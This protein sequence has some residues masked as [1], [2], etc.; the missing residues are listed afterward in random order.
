MA[1]NDYDVVVVGGGP[2]GSSAA[3][4]L[5]GSG[6]NVLLA[7]KAKSPREKVCGE[8][9]TPRAIRV[10]R[11]MGLKDHREDNFFKVRGFRI[12]YR[13]YIA[14]EFL[15][16][17]VPPYPDYMYTIRRPELDYLLLERARESGAL[18][19]EECKVTGPLLEE[20]RVVGVRAVQDGEEV[21][22]TAR[23]VIGA[24]G[25]H[26]TL[27]KALGLMV[28]DQSNI[29]LAVRQLFEGV[30]GLDDCVDFYYLDEIMPGYCWIFPMS[31]NIANVGLGSYAQ[32]IREN[33]MDLQGLMETL[34][35]HTSVSARFKNARAVSPLRGSILRMGMKCS[36]IECPGLILIGDAASMVNPSNG[37]G[38]SYALETGRMAAE[39][40]L[41]SK[42]GN[43]GIHHDPEENS[44]K[45]KLTTRYGKY[46]AAMRWSARHLLGASAFW[47][48]HNALA[49]TP[50]YRKYYAII[51]SNLRKK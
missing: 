41:A 36:R 3:Y 20:G 21:E 42:H 30:E 15:I 35:N 13:E 10:M 22:I 1:T 26:S 29:A 8:C 24:D 19:W 28:N 25:V 39:H 37:E 9:V 44:F 18:V 49:S 47:R 51:F 16:P 31:K 38:I 12:T 7:E 33:K 27:G 34:V 11:D 6:V 50:Q 46:Y 14:R 17:S 32:N 4:W 43:S 40:I 45:D 48:A 5:A 2:A 23:V